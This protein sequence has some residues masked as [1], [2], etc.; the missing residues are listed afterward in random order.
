[1]G[2]VSFF[3]SAMT[4]HVAPGKIAENSFIVTR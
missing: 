2:T 3:G 1:M 4:D